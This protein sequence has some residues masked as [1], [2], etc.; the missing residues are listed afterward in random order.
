MSFIL[1]Q[2]TKSSEKSIDPKLLVNRYPSFES[3]VEG[4]RSVVSDFIVDRIGRK[5]FDRDQWKDLANN[6]T[7]RDGFVI[8]PIPPKDNL[9][10]EK[11]GAKIVKRTGGYVKHFFEYFDFLKR[12]GDT[13]KNGFL[14][15][16]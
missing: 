5:N 12:F 2:H 6:E 15:Y 3:A 7:I 4:L 8:L 10:F 11:F 13:Q 14:I 1:Y 9:G 16:T